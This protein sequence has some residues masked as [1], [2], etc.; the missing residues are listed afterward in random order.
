MSDLTTRVREAFDS[1]SVPEGLKAHTL[2][3]I[4]EHDTA[5]ETTEHGAPPSPK[6]KHRHYRTWYLATAACFMLV[7]LCLFGYRTYTTETAYVSVDL[8]P[9]IELGLNCFSFV[10][11]EQAFNADGEQILAETSFLGMPYEKAIDLLTGTSLTQFVRADA[12]LDISIMSTN[13]RQA[14]MLMDASAVCLEVLPYFGTCRAVSAQEHADAQAAHMG[15]G[16]YVAASLLMELNPVFTMDE[17]RTMSMRALQREIE[18]AGGQMPQ[19]HSNEH[20][21]MGAGSDSANRNGRGAQDGSGQ[22][23][24][25]GAQGNGGQSGGNGVQDGSGHGAQSHGDH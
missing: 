14:Q 3:Y 23:G 19:G 25:S 22:G 12:Y 2:T 5:R 7:A 24:S 18:A 16:R 8:N 21:G 17:C 10:I 15:V 9:S 13:A 1:V 4:A 6:T 11:S 20:G